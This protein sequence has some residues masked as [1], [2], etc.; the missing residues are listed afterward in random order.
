MT[1]YCTQCVLND[2]CVADDSLCQNGGT[3]TLLSSPGNYTCNCTGTGYIGVNCTGM[4]VIIII[5]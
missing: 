1:T 5:I 2:I 3:C 4:L